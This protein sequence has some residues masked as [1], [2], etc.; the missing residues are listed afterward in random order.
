MNSFSLHARQWR[1]PFKRL[2]YWPWTGELGRDNSNPTHTFYSSVLKFEEK[3]GVVSPAWSTQWV[4]GQLEIFGDLVLRKIKNKKRRKK[5]KGCTCVWTVYIFSVFFFLLTGA[6]ASVL[7]LK[8]C[9][10]VWLDLWPDA[11]QKKYSKTNMCFIIEL[12]ILKLPLGFLWM[13]ENGLQHAFG[14]LGRRLPGGWEVWQWAFSLGSWQPP[15]WVIQM[16]PA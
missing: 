3:P 16:P 2:K 11:L 15:L 8:H 13:K 9:G 1:Y 4:P 5:S 10:Y 12:G 6:V 7:P 14:G